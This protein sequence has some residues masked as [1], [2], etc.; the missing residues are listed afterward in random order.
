MK[1]LFF[2]LSKLSQNVFFS[3]VTFSS[4]SDFSIKIELKSWV[5]GKH[6]FSR[7]WLFAKFFIRILPEGRILN[8]ITDFLKFSSQIFIVQE[9]VCFRIWFL[10][11]WKFHFKLLFSMKNLLQ[12]H[13]F[14]M[15]TQSE[16]LFVVRGANRVRTLFLRR[17]VFIEIW[18]LNKNWTQNLILGNN[19]VSTKWLFENF[20]YR[21]QP[22]RKNLDSKTGQFV[23]KNFTSKF[24]FFSKSS[25]PKSDF[26][27]KGLLQNHAF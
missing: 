4:K 14:K 24:D 22:G 5:S 3:D 17:D 7:V 19:F 15:S 10:F 13:D 16:K 1:N 18:F 20:F 21:S 23:G 25:F 2:L 6:F 27:G 26:Q 8:S 9:N 12:S 11:F